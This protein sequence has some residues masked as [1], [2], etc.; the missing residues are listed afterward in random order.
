MIQHGYKIIDINIDPFI[1][2]FLTRI[3]DIVGMRVESIPDY[4]KLVSDSQHQQIKIK[5]RWMILNDEMLRE[6]RKSTGFTSD[7]KASGLS[8][9]P[10]Q[11][12]D[13]CCWFL[14]RPEPYEDMHPLLHSDK[15]CI[16]NDYN[17]WLPLSGFGQEYSLSI[18]PDS[19]LNDNSL[20]VREVGQGST[21]YKVVEDN[22]NS[23]RPDIKRG[24]GILFNSNLVHGNAH[25]NGTDTR[26]SLEIRFYEN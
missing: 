26:V 24:Q 10:P 21:S 14:V 15:D 6:I 16:G 19:H 9:K 11:E 22:G 23:I 4:H 12:F 1:S 18:V 13:V 25:N 2:G 20:D 17:I 5:N 3:S 8:T 7:I